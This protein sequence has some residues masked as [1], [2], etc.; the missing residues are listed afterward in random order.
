MKAHL[1][2]ARP[3]KQS[4]DTVQRLW[5]TTVIHFDSFFLMYPNP[6]IIWRHQT[7]STCILGKPL[8]TLS[9]IPPQLEFPTYSWLKQWD[10]YMHVN[11][12]HFLIHTLPTRAPP[13][14]QFDNLKFP[15]E[16]WKHP[17]GWHPTHTFCMR[18]PQ[19][20]T[21]NHWLDVTWEGL[22]AN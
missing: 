7:A 21:H 5:T 17:N 8:G 10:F 19:S 6:T 4:P 1:S 12:F 16:I 3:L 11:I 20:P 15:I 13:T 9:Q 14:Q 2:K 22:S 18:P